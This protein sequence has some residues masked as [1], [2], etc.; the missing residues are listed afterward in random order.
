[1]KRKCHVAKGA[2]LTRLHDKFVERRPVKLSQGVVTLWLVND[3]IEV[4]DYYDEL[5]IEEAEDTGSRHFWAV[6]WLA[7]KVGFSKL[8]GKTY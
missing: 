7:K 6:Q 1:V 4:S 5:E 2:V 3:E 8:E